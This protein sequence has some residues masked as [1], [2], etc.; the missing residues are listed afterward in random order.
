MTAAVV[1]IGNAKPQ[2]HEK[3]RVL[4]SELDRQTEAGREDPNDRLGCSVD[5]DP[6]ADDRRLAAIP[7]VPELVRQYHGGGSVRQI[8]LGGE[9][10]AED[11][12]NADD[13]Q[14]VASDQPRPESLRLGVAAEI[15]GRVVEGGEPVEC[16]SLP[17]IID[18][19]R[20]GEP[21]LWP[22]CPAVP[23]NHDS[24]GV[25]VRQRAK[26]YP[27]DDAE[28]RRV[29]ADPEG[30]REHDSGS[31]TRLVTDAAKRVT[32]ILRECV[33]AVA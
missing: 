18:D 28:H 14:Q 21:R 27:V 30:Q 2:R 3:L 4:P 17:G 20:A 10:A 7:A 26:E 16:L 24:I 5:G 11:R 12:A 8:L 32:D 13:V 9:A 22:S 33:D 25:G 6:S 23:H 29:R 19:L 31:E 15:H 1:L